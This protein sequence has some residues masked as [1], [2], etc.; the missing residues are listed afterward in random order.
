MAAEGSSKPGDGGDAAHPHPSVLSVSPDFIRAALDHAGACMA[1]LV[2]PDLRFVLVNRAYQALV[3]DLSMVGRTLAEVFPYAA[4]SGVEEAF[5]RVLH[6]GEPWRV[7]RYQGPVQGRPGAVWQGEVVRLP[8]RDGEPAAIVVTALDV[9]DRVHAE[10]SLASSRQAQKAQHH[11]LECMVANAGA[12]IAVLRG[13]D[14]RYSLVNPAY[15]A[16]APG[17]QMLGRTY[18]EVFPDAAGRG[19]LE[20]FHRVLDTGE[21]WVVEAYAAPIPGKADARWEGRVVRLP[22]EPG[23]ELSV[24]VEIWDV[25]ERVRAEEAVRD[26]EQRYRRLIEGT[27]EGVWVLDTDGNTT[28]VND[29]MAAL[30]GYA[31]HEM[32]G[33]NAFEFVWPDDVQRGSAEWEERRTITGGRQSEYRYRHKDG[34]PVWCLAT[35]SPLTD[36]TG[37]TVGVF[38]MFADITERKQAEERY[39]ALFESM[40]EGCVVGRMIY[41]E[42]GHA[43]D[44]QLTEANP[45][46]ERLTGV[47]RDESL[48][49]TMKQLIP[50]LEPT[51]VEHHARVAQTGRSEH[52]EAYNRHVDQ[53]YE[54]YSFSPAPGLF[55]SMFLNV[56]ERK[57]V[58]ETLEQSGKRLSAALEV[59]QLGVWEYDVATARSHYDRR[60]R[61]VFGIIT[62]RPT[63]NDEVFELIHPEDRPRVERDMKGAL[64]PTGNGVYDSE[65]RV[66]HPDGSQRWLAVRGYAIR[67]AAHSELARF[68]GTVMDVTERKR[69]EET[70]R[71][72]EADLQRE[73]AFLRTVIDAVASHVLVKDRAGRVLLANEAAARFHGLVPRDLEGT[74]CRS[75]ATFPPDTCDQDR[76]VLVSGR[77]RAI[78]REAVGAD[79]QRHFLISSLT[80]LPNDKGVPDRVLTTSADITWRRRAE[81]AQRAQAELL[82]AIVDNIPVLLTI[83]DPTL[84]SFQFNKH[85]RDVLGWTEEDAAGVD[86]F[87]ACVYPDPAYREQVVDYMLALH[88]GW[89][90]LLTTAKDGTAVDISWAN[91]ELPEGRSIGIG[92]EV[93]KRKA[94]EAEL[95][96]SH[97]MLHAVMEHV[98]EG[99]SICDADGRFILS[100]KA[101]LALT[102][103]MVGEDAAAY[104]SK[105]R[106]LA[107]DGMTPLALDEL[108][109]MRAIRRGETV[110]GEEVVLE[111]W[112]G[113]CLPILCNAAPIRDES[114]GI[115]GAVL[116]YQ[117]ISER[118]R[119]E[120]ALREADRRKDE[121][122]AVLSHE[123]RNPLAPIRYALPI[124]QEERFS[125]AAG[126]AMAAINRQVD[127]LARL[128]DDLLDVSRITRGKIELR[129]EYVTLASVVQASVEAA[130]P[131]IAFGSHTLKL[132]VAEEPIWVHADL[133]RMVQVVTNL[134]NNSAKYT[135]RG[136][137]IVLDA[138]REGA[139]AVIS[140]RDNG[141]GITK[142][143]LAS[144]FEMF[145]QVNRA[146]GQGGLGI[147]LALAKRL[148]EMHEGR[149]EARSAGL[150][151][152]AE[153]VLRVPAQA[154][155]N[156]A[157]VQHQDRTERRG[158][159]LRVLVVDDNI[160]LTEMLAMVIEAA[161]HHV[162]KAFDGRSAVSAARAYAPD[163]V[164]LDLGLPGMSGLEVA[165]ELRRHP[166]TAATRLIAVTGWGQ[167]ED[168]QRT[169]AAGFDHHLTKPTDPQSLQ[170]LL[171]ELAAELPRAGTPPTPRS[172]WEAPP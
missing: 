125:E 127:H 142:D 28:Y 18:S 130:A 105:N 42:Q 8:S 62:D 75:I 6:T 36:A 53:H 140:V 120:D 32:I 37:R 52:W 98:P 27:H 21:P 114:A 39:R 102:R 96:R 157:E 34:R 20:R 74:D 167:A 50:G 117:D 103:R 76:A 88:P 93:G 77:E 100:S 152:G 40:S 153:F 158:R 171:A 11:L 22:E 95:R 112:D 58:Q 139:D 160:D 73:R 113:V 83:W 108:P 15:Q 4:A 19:A 172:A 148:V 159:P 162:R 41:D 146:D 147:G 169:S 166:E 124:L 86:D 123:L 156:Q 57:R 14:L 90:D 60:C 38:G 67:A 97:Q 168:R 23:Q 128:V 104:A 151:E 155:G 91:V 3:P 31:R 1:I 143:A 89:K 68:V 59:A 66:L 126:R 63:S 106:V 154:G 134:L 24:L 92:I 133:P 111:R 17:I 122:I 49:N 26:S 48:R 145:R 16:L 2:G 46:Y 107:A 55:A 54:V 149:I 12:S 9:T 150:G 25:T 71:E 129:R 137:E 65:Y 135:Q 81:Q 87:M 170:R 64:D 85:L 51:W 29:Q 84:K 72:R 35:S 5:R 121:F 94:M 101:G 165:A 144:I 10:E 161:G 118:K 119:M 44:Y 115:V 141:L 99:V 30:L 163:V 56:T 79:G 82:T 138:W 136:G 80:P 116:A 132:N 33:R 109:V 47:P 131:V 13:R 61:E 70:I 78:E 69:A 45:A 43:I 7:D 110:I 164:L